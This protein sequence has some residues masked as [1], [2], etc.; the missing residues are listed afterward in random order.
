MEI[1]YYIVQ[2]ELGKTADPLFMLFSMHMKEEIF[3]L[4]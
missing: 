2:L 1:Y 4:P 3:C